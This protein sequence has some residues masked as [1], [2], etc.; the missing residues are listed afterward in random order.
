M[1]PLNILDRIVSLTCADVMQKQ[2]LFVDAHSSMTDVA[3][4]FQE[5]HISAAPVVDETNSFVGMLSA[6]DFVQR[7]ASDHE[8]LLQR[9]ERNSCWEINPCQPDLACHYMSCEI[10]TA[11]P[12][13]PLL[14]AAQMITCLHLHRIP[15]VDSGR[16]VVG[17]VSTT[18]ITAALVNV[19]D[20][21]DPRLLLPNPNLP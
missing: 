12:E 16:Q 3:R 8:H 5:N 19:V 13:T 10:Q 14:Q 15:I 6:S 20:E 17:I 1:A 4:L 9:S 21:H 18:D 2:V 7:D 11:R